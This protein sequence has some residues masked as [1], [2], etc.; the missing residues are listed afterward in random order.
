MSEQNW[1]YNWNGNLL[2]SNSQPQY[3][4]LI[5]LK[6]DVFTGF[7]RLNDDRRTEAQ[8]ASQRA[9]VRSLQLQTIAQ[10]WRAYYDFQT[11]EKKY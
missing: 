7:H 3:A 2:A 5:G 10:V 8:R 6:W 11:A 9:S 4:A 1:W